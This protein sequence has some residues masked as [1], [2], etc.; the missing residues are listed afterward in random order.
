MSVNRCIQNGP[1]WLPRS[2]AEG[3]ASGESGHDVGLG[4]EGTWNFPALAA[5]GGM[6]QAVSLA[7]AAPNRGNSATQTT[8][9]GISLL[10]RRLLLRTVVTCQV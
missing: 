5:A 6:A 9:Q 4:G 3:P 2:P 7:S 10:A 1:I 8:V